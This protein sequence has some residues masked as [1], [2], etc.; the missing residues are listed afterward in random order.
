MLVKRITA[1]KDK[2]TVEWEGNLESFVIPRDIL[3]G[4]RGRKP[5]DSIEVLS[6]EP[7]I[8][9]P[10]R[11][12]PAPELAVCPVELRFIIRFDVKFTGS[13]DKK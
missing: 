8:T 7:S 13:I 1:E 11:T 3:S 10:F 9:P 2:L 6:P 12:K 5:K 4:K